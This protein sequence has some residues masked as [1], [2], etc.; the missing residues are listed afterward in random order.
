MKRGFTLLELVISTAVLISVFSVIA[1]I[2]GRIGTMRK[3]AEAEAEIYSGAMSILDIVEEDLENIC[4][5][6][7]LYASDGDYF[8]FIR[9]SRSPRGTSPGG[10]YENMPFTRVTYAKRGGN[11]ESRETARIREN[12]SAPENTNGT[13]LQERT[14][15]YLAGDGTMSVTNAVGG[16]GEVYIAGASKG[17]TIS[18]PVVSGTAKRI[19]DISS[20]YSGWAVVSEGDGTEEIPAAVTAGVTFTNTYSSTVV[21][22]IRRPLTGAWPE[23]GRTSWSLLQRTL[24]VSEIST[25]G[26]ALSPAL[27]LEEAASGEVSTNLFT[28]VVTNGVA[29]IEKDGIEEEVGCLITNS[30]RTA[31]FL[32]AATND[33][34]ASLAALL[35]YSRTST[36][37]ATGYWTYGTPPAAGLPPGA[38]VTNPGLSNILNTV[39]NTY[40]S[41]SDYRQ[42][43]AFLR[44]AKFDS[45]ILAPAGAALPL[46]S[47]DSVNAVIASKLDGFAAGKSF[48]NHFY[49]N[50]GGVR[51]P[52]SIS[53]TE[54][55][56]PSLSQTEEGLL[57]AYGTLLTVTAAGTDTNT[58][59]T[60]ASGEFLSLLS[61]ESQVTDEAMIVASTIAYRS[62]TFYEAETSIPPGIDIAPG[63]YTF[64]GITTNR[65]V[66]AYSEDTGWEEIILDEDFDGGTDTITGLWLQTE[67]VDRTK[68]ESMEE[69]IRL[70]GGYGAALSSPEM[71]GRLC[72]DN[73]NAE[74]RIRILYFSD[75]ETPGADY[76]ERLRLISGSDSAADEEFGMP[77]DTPERA[78]PDCADIELALKR[79]GDPSGTTYYFRRRVPLKTRNQWSPP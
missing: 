74:I 23:A 71:E 12:W 42:Y 63:P 19:R 8:S 57:P 10:A 27:L 5:T 2:T 39:T 77:P 31:S 50:P 72:G 75:G 49:P 33:P 38:Q 66:T 22:I 36:N 6:N 60:A 41:S 28:E 67:E 7:V 51:I 48:V 73:L 56:T 30:V 64:S 34:P 37:P 46:T 15:Y 76:R 69:Y 43:D 68:L 59:L 54:S 1:M 62:A 65:D 78:I 18:I 40:G 53:A 52:L 35:T 70:P 13:N 58:L 79:R 16:S 44:N 32:I 45:A 25:P 4:G 17:D 26:T 47:N 3:E 61:V 11:D 55:F 14:V 29:M 21:K 20:A 24:F 9:S